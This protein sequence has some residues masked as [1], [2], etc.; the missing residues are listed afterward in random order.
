MS[1]VSEL[2]LSRVAHPSAIKSLRHA[3]MAFL[4]A[5]DVSEDCAADIATAVGEALANAAE[6]AYGENLSGLVEVYARVEP[7]GLV[8]EVL[9]RGVFVERPRREGRGFGLRIMK[10]VAR[11][12]SID[13]DGGTRVR[14]VFDA[15]YVR[16]QP[17]EA[18]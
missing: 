3:F 15:R 4:R 2:R 8:V 18:S 12:V 6:H 5:N 14:M 17:L 11:T 10:A 13:H 1:S 7:E 16:S 9:D